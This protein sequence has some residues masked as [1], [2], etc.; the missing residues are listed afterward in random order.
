MSLTTISVD[1]RDYPSYATLAEAT[2]Q[3]AIDPVRGLS[4]RAAD[5]PVQALALVASSASLDALTWAGRPQ[6]ENQRPRA[7]GRI[8]VVYP[9]GAVVP[10][11]ALPVAIQTATIIIAAN[12]L[13]TATA[14]QPAAVGA[15]TSRRIKAGPVEIEY[16][17]PAATLSVQDPEAQRLIAPYLAAAVGRRAIATGTD[18]TSAFD[19][20]EAPE[21]VYY[22]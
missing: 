14:V 4:W 10:D 9:D 19:D 7:W 2:I 6:T 3:L 17:A 22:P 18:G 13:T 21:P 16:F 20:R 12:S 5:E 8:G 1:G 11:G 15:A